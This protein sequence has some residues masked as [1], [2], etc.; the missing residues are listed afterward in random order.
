[1]ALGD[2]EASTVSSRGGPGDRMARHTSGLGCKPPS[3][4]VPAVLGGGVRAGVTY[5]GD[6]DL[7]AEWKS[8][9]LAAGT[10]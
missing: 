3:D 7:E 9:A 8:R 2:S 4:A 6:G 5:G 1:M 10:L